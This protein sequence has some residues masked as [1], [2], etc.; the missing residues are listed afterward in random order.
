MK[1]NWRKVIIISFV[2]IALELILSIIFLTPYYRVRRVFDNIDA[3]RW[4]EAKECFEQLNDKA[5]RRGYRLPGF[6][7]SMGVSELH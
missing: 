5:K 6:L 3:G 7:R 2:L 1:K 4:Q